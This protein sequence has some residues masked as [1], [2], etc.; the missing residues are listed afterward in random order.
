LEAAVMEE[1]ETALVDP[2][3]SM[4]AVEGGGAHQSGGLEAA[5]AVGGQAA[6][7]PAE[8]AQEEVAA[9]PPEAM[10]DVMEEGQVG[11]WSHQV[12]VE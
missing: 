6:A 5:L 7:K 12:Q 4:A 2:E 1:V 3:A 8:V 9:V 11:L 10:A